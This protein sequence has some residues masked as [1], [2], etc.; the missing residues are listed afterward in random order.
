MVN[1][2]YY[3]EVMRETIRQKHTELWRNQSWSWHYDNAPAH[4]SMLVRTFLAK[5][6]TV[7]RPQPPYLPDLAPAEFF[8]F[9]ELKTPTKGKRFATIEEIKEKSK[10]EMLAVPLGAFQK[11]FEGLE[12]TL[13]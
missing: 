9:P 13:A 12:K 11:C 10:Q 2:E 4:T 1:K 7:I 8:P 3:V 6:K 5:N